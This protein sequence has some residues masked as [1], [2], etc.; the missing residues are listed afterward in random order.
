MGEKNQAL[1][2]YANSI[3]YFRQGGSIPATVA[4]IDTLITCIKDSRPET[5]FY[6]N[7]KKELL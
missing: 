2:A 3:D 4:T 6:E 1:N 7:M 5:E